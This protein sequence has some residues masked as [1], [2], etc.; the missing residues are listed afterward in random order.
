MLR[1]I[2]IVVLAF[3]AMEGVSYAV[4]RYVYHGFLWF[5]HRSH[6]APRKGRF[7][8]NDLFPLHFASI[9]IVLMM[10]GLSNPEARD[11]LAL[12]IGITLYGMV[13]LVIHDLYVHR[14]MQSLTFKNP[15]MLKIKK[16]HMVHHSHGGE[17]YGLLLFSLPGHAEKETGSQGD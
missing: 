1:F 8:W 6:H 10:I 14:R 7:E 5:I 11:I 13:Y 16:A 2:M 12:S 17:P 9:S 3:V 15:F 4:H